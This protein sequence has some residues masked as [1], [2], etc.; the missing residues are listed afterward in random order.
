[1]VKNLSQLDEG[2]DRLGILLEVLEARRRCCAAVCSVI[3]EGADVLA[4]INQGMP[5]CEI[6]REVK[7]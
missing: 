1:M 7:E 6:Y 3:N 2:S 5:L 4:T